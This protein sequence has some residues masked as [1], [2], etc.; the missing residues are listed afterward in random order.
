MSMQRDSV[1]GVRRPASGI[2]IDVPRLI[3]MQDERGWDR[4]RLA[5]ESGVSVSMIAKIETG[6]RKPSTETL[7]KIC[8]A[9]RCRP[10]ALLPPLPRARNREQQT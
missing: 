7:G 3:R 1:S 4:A 8:K 6:E 2:T 10:A 5:A 9:F